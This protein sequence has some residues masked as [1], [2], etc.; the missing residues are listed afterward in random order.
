MI[1]GEE[2]GKLNTLG[3]KMVKKKIGLAGQLVGE[4][5]CCQACRPEV[6]PWDSHSRRKEN[7]P[8]EDVLWP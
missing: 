5:P 2:N 1:H 8:L 7:S 4:D 3:L 6:H